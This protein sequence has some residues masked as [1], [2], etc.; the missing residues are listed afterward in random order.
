M[1]PTVTKITLTILGLLVL[2]GLPAA[3]KLRQFHVMSSSPVATPPTTITAAGA[4]RQSWPDTL[5]AVGTLVAVQGVTVGAELGG[6]ITAVLFDSGDRVQAGDLLI[7]LDTSTEQAQLR[8]ADAATELAR[9]NLERT[10]QLLAKQTVSKSEFDTAEARFKQ[11]VADAD[12]IRAVIGKKQLRAPFAGRLGLRLVNLG[13]ILKEGD[14]IVT[15][16]TLD[17][18]YVDFSLPQQ[19]FPVIATGTGVRVSTD[20]APG[21]SFEGK[22]NAVNPEIDSLTRNVRV[23]ATISNVGEKLRPGM[24][25][26]VEI[27]L[28]NEQEVLAIPATA[29]LY[30]PYGDTVFVV[31]E[32]KNS[33]AGKQQNV[34][35]QQIVR[36]G[37]TRGD[38]VSVLSGLEAGDRVASSGVFKLRPDMPVVID[39]TLAPD[40][41]L[42]PAPPEK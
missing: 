27:V 35:R 15:L 12:N 37:E 19:Q 24:F 40:A 18:I 21:E 5:T 36:L 6:K 25:A 16:Q 28:P 42:S 7:R 34:L 31:E 3:I 20:A 1:H 41:Q 23:Q 8:S 2:V 32:E 11:A 9:I 39:N 30:A 4:S 26:D 22:I 38:F 29:V 14:P 33:P 10:R 17:P 13:Q